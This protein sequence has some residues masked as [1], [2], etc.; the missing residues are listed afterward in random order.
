MIKKIL[1]LIIMFYCYA[2]QAQKSSPVMGDAAILLDLLKKDYSSVNPD[3]K[4]EEINTDREKVIGIFKSYLRDDQKNGL[5]A[6]DFSNKLESDKK[7]YTE[8]LQSYNAVLKTSITANKEYNLTTLEGE[9]KT[10]YNKL[11]TCKSSYYTSKYYSDIDQ[12]GKIQVLYDTVDNDTLVTNDNPYLVAVI[13]LFETKYENVELN[14]LDNFAQNNYNSSIQKSLPFI[15]GDLAFETLIDGLSRFLAKRIKQELTVYAIDKI[16]KYL[17]D[18]KPENYSQELVVV[19]PKT[20]NYLKRFDANQLM[21]FTNELKQLIEEDLNNILINAQGLRDLPKIKKYTAG[22]PDLEFAFD[23]LEVLSQLSKVKT[24]VDYFELLE[25]SRGLAGWRDDATK[26]PEKYDIA[27]GI[28][29]AS[30]LAY[31][32]TVV[33]NGEQRFASIDFLSNY[34]S[35]AKFYFMYFGFL[36]QQNQKYFKINF[37]NNIVLNVRG[38]MDLMPV[39]DIENG[40]KDFNFI[41]DNITSVAQYA[42]KIHTTAQSIK[43]KNKNNEEI[44]YEE[45][46]DFVDEIIEFTQ[47]VIVTAD[48]LLKKDYKFIVLPEGAADFDFKAKLNPYFTVASTGNDLVFDLHQKKYSNAIIKAVEIPLLLNRKNTK[49]SSDLLDIKYLVEQQNDLVLLGKVF[50]PTVTPEQLKALKS[51]LKI[52]SLKKSDNGKLKNIS[53]SLDTLINAIA[54]KTYDAKRDALGENIKLA[55]KENKDELLDYFGVDLKKIKKQITAYLQEKNQS[56]A[57]RDQFVKVIDSYAGALFSQV[58]L[59]EPDNTGSSTE[60]KDLFIAFAPDFINSND[61]LKDGQALKI[62]NFLNDISLAATPEDVEKAIDA[63]ALP[64]GSSSLKERA[65]SYYAINS[66]PG[67]IG[68]FEFSDQQPRAETIGFTAP[69]GLYFQPWGAFKKGGSLGIFLPIIDIAAP[70]R[71]RLDSNNDTQTLPE[72]DFKDIFS[73]G[74]YL[75]YG[76][77]N[78]PIALNLGMQYGPKLRDIPVGDGSVESVDSYR[79]NVGVTIDIPL[80]TL[81]GKYK[82]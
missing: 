61:I 53:M 19:L 30:M 25:K 37:S 48:V 20:T 64:V 76:F 18:P 24:P 82:N 35:D 79:V 2:L 52:L 81:S 51:P 17:N 6:T 69:V 50:N 36:H 29:L 57:V 55:L 65:T 78:S 63:F 66:F 7:E 16:K 34:G 5:I 22:H 68:G 73:P 12:L 41:R 74:V 9:L 45:I 54:D 21:S 56:R 3:I 46:H 59:H 70:V 77:R 32:L 23:G 39:S 33:E 72:F 11:L 40:T 42:E 80:L 38:L 26:N 60:L 43:K 13:E 10:I 28:R 31:S 47:Q 27:Q 49:L 1:S 67:I 44:K 62:I 8:S 15:G 58:V 4:L 75:I 14:M 71:L